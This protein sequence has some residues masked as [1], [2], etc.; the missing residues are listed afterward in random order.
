MPKYYIRDGQ[1]QAIIDSHN[2]LSACMVAVLKKF[3]S[4]QVNGHYWVSERG[5][6]PHPEN[7]KID[8][9]IVNM[10]ISKS[11]G[12]NLEDFVDYMDENEEKFEDDP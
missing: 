5:F 9:N 1:E 12:F 6:T 10:L 2:A 3:N 4:I 11:L 8:S 7:V